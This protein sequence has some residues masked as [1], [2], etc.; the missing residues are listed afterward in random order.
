[1]ADEKGLGLDTP[2]NIYTDE[3]KEEFKN[4][5]K[6]NTKIDKRQKI[7]EDLDTA[8]NR[9]QEERR[10]KI[11]RGQPGNMSSTDA[12]LYTFKHSEDPEERKE[13]QRMMR[14]NKRKFPF[15][16]KKELA[17]DRL[18]KMKEREEAQK[19]QN[20]IALKHVEDT[21]HKYSS[22]PLEINSQ[23][24]FGEVETWGMTVDEFIKK[25]AELRATKERSNFER[26]FGSKGISSI[27]KKL[28]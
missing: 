16:Y 7:K 3:F 4:L 12:I 11:P 18:A 1:M 25:K 20:E 8:F 17:Q 28:I 10:A 6:L 9:L 5:Q 2:L 27:Y 26:Q 22:E 23:T 13:Y 14:E 19:K 15:L 24:Q 21:I